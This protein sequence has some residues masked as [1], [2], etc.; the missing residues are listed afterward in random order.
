M[1][2]IDPWAHLLNEDQLHSPGLH[3]IA[4]QLQVLLVARFN[5]GVQAPARAPIHA[6]EVHVG[7]RPEI[8]PGRGPSCSTDDAQTHNGIGSPGEW[9][10]MMLNPP[11][12]LALMDNGVI[13]NEAFVDSRIGDLPSVGRNPESL[14][15]TH[16]FLSNKLRRTVGDRVTRPSC[17]LDR[18]DILEIGAPQLSTP[19]V[20]CPLAIRGQLCIDRGQVGAG[21]ELQILARTAGYVELT[22]DWD[23]EAIRILGPEELGNPALA[24]ALTLA[25]QCLFRVGRL[26]VYA[27]R[28]GAREDS[29]LAALEVERPEI[30]GEIAAIAEKKGQKPRV[31]GKCKITRDG[32]PRAGIASHGVEIEAPL[33]SGKL[34]HAVL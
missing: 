27:T 17:Q 1:V 5:L 25:A 18:A 33:G 7:V 21:H 32:H 28:R 22:V 34:G 31:R 11:F 30:P 9:I 24:H 16:L 8:Q 4:P 23:Q 12:G 2:D 15:A 29:T 20:Y 6:R 26:V 14:A 13:R 10:A 3:V 19:H